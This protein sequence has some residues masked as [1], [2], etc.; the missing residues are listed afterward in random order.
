[1]IEHI[2]SEIIV[3][4][5]DATN[6]LVRILSSKKNSENNRKNINKKNLAPLR[7]NH[8]NQYLPS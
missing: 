5:K 4:D 8:R 3:L 1:M 2:T 6:K 7:T